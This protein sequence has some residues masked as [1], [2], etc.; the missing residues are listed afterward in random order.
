MPIRLGANRYGKAENRVVRIHRD[1]ARHEITDL[2][3]TTHLRGPSTPPT[4]RVTRQ[5]C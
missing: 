3:V 1:T 2:N 5:P 4:R